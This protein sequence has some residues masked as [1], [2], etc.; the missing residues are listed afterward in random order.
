MRWVVWSVYALVLTALL[1]TPYPV[2]AAHAVLPS[3]EAKF[4]AGKSLHLAGYAA[5]AALSGGLPVPSRGR[6]LLLAALSLHAC[7]T[8][9][10]QHLVP[11]RSGAWQDV[12]L[13]HTGLY[14]GVL[15]SWAWWRRPD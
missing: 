9:V 12:M 8:E 6:W 3:A 5:F 13:N 7:G 1:T 2:R 10:V 15:L 4:T 11:S 14:L